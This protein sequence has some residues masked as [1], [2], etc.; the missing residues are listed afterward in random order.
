MRTDNPR[1]YTFDIAIVVLLAAMPLAGLYYFTS[2]R[3]SFT[4]QW[5]ADWEGHRIVV[6]QWLDPLLREGEELL[7]DGVAV[8]GSSR[9]E[10]KED[11][12][13]EI[14]TNGKVRRIHARIC[15]T[16]EIFYPRPTLSSSTVAERTPIKAFH[17]TSR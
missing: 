12:Y 16:Y 11:L 17:G 2:H 6:K 1:V 3:L 5:E 4:W 13:G 15:H 7:I 10:A 9:I 8:A 14:Q